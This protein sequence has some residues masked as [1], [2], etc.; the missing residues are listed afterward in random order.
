MKISGWILTIFGG[1]VSFGGLIQIVDN[2]DGFYLPSFLLAVVLLV[3][4]LV[5]L[6]RQKKN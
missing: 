5:I 4:G 2:R 1:V 3:I 6:N